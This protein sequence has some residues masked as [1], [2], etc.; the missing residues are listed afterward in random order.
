MKKEN[1]NYYLYISWDNNSSR[2]KYDKDE[3]LSYMMVVKLIA[4]EEVGCTIQ[5][6]NDNIFII[7]SI[8]NYD[9][10]KNKLQYK[11]FPYILIDITNNT[12]LGT[13]SMYL[14]NSEIELLNDFVVEKDKEQLGYYQLKLQESVVNEDYESAVFYRD[15]IK[16]KTTISV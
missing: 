10:L 3:F 12:K 8:H 15:L 6:L 9:I 16:E 11:K 2:G 13:L 4:E 14:D 5:A 1:L 7:S